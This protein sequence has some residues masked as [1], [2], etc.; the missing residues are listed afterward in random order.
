MNSNSTS[1]SLPLYCSSLSY[2]SA[3]P[4]L[5]LSFKICPVF[6][7]SIFSLIQFS[8]SSLSSRRGCMKGKI[9]TKLFTE[10]FSVRRDWDF[11]FP[12]CTKLKKNFQRSKYFRNLVFI[13]RICQGRCTH[14]LFIS[15]ELSCGIKHGPWSHNGSPMTIH[16][17]SMS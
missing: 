2:L 7:L 4:L 15:P 9:S 5:F 12:L 16:M 17:L 14:N 10:D 13:Y 8:S 6:T 3:P 1:L 11:I